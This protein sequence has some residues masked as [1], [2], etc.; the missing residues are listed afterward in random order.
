MYPLSRP[1]TLRPALPRPT[2]RL[3]L[4]LVLVLVAAALAIGW[5]VLSKTRGPEALAEASSLR[6][7]QI[8]ELT[9]SLT[10]SG[11]AGDG[12]EVDAILTTPD[13]FRLTRRSNDAASYRADRVIVFVANETVHSGSLPHHFS[14][15]LRLDGGYHVPSEVRVLTDAEHHRTS[16]VIFDDLPIS[17]LAEPRQIQMLLAPASTG[18]RATLAWDTPIDY[19]ASIE[20]PHALTLGLLLSLTAGLMAAIS[21][22]LLQLTAFYLPTIAGVSAAASADG[23]SP[24]HQ[25]RNVLGTAGLFILGF[26]I[27][28]TA[29]GVLMGSIGERLAQSNLL[30]QDGPIV[31]GA[32]LV[33]ILMAG[34]VAYRAKAPLVCR[35]PM[36]GALR[37]RRRLPLLTPFISGFAMATGCLACFGGAVLGVLLVYAGLLG[38]PL[39]GGLAMFVFSM[40]IAIPFMAAALSISWVMPVADRLHRWTPAIGFVSAAIMLFFGI[41]MASGHFHVVSGWLSQKLPL[42]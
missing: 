1:H 3:G 2:V 27:P 37:R 23:L 32:G 16:V 26:T 7:S 14:P 31:V 36:P 5:L 29:G 9:A 10:R 13:F 18:A 38:S 41:I 34:V 28:Y 24:R 42:A 11:L 25:R 40:G 6:R 30:K 35:V 21:P 15:I 20:N 8:A 33:M 22:C 17:L 4:S 39:L 19:P 12:V